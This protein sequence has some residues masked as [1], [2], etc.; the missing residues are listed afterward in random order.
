MSDLDFSQEKT[1]EGIPVAPGIA[2]GTLYIH[3]SDDE[4]PPCIELTEADLPHEVQ[5]FEAALI[6]TRAQIID[7][8]QRIA[9]AIGAKDASIFD[10]HLL[11]VEDRTLI[12]EVLRTLEAKKL[13]VETIFLSVANRYSDTLSKIDDPY[14]R[15]RAYDIHDVTRR[16]IRNLLGKTGRPL[17]SVDYPHIIAAQNLTP[18]D[19]ALLNRE[20]VL[21]FATEG[22]SKTSH[23]AIMAR[24]LDIPAV[25]G[26]ENFM[27]HLH[28]GQTILIDGYQGCVFINPTAATLEKYGRIE[29]QKEQVEERLSELRE[30]LSTTL[31]GRRIVLSANIELTNDL[32][33]VQESGAEGIGLYRTEFLYLNRTDYPTEEEQYEI[34]LK[35]A[36]A[37]LPHSVIIRTMDIGG[38]KFV[39]NERKEPNPFLGCRAIRLCLENVPVFKTQLRA[40]LRA[41]AVG[42]VRI[43]YPMISSLE[44]LRKANAILL[45]CKNELR[46]EGQAFGEKLDVGVMIEVPSAALCADLLAREVS[47]FSIG[48]ND[49]I[50]YTVAVDRV[51][52]QIAHLYQPTHPAVLRLIKMVVRAA[53]S[54]GIWVG[55]CGEMAG[56]VSLTPLLLGLGIDELSASVPSVPRIKRAVQT[57]NQ[58]ECERLADHV[59]NFDTA[60]EI[61]EVV[62]AHAREHYG[63][64]LG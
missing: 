49:L 11:V 3:H 42:N 7:M 55:V 20:F 51:N 50:Q 10:A 19:T 34:Y 35:V 29:V 40:I 26:L 36:R 30:T 45:E 41:S 16:V 1:F 58:S 37:T 28:E 64:L 12:D 25:A 46:G 48:T 62:E 5:R 14:L 53:H 63:E 44:E 33:A 38:D 22:G 32:P 6:A 13:N 57:L 9:V 60:Q 8:Q 23:T 21:G 4:V 56:D 24:S 15:E 17:S 54:A 27:G 31:D 59:L 43:M 47:F 18:S 2:H 61:L 52:E 39:G